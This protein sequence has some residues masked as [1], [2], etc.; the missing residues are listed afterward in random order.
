MVAPVGEGHQDGAPSAGRGRST[1]RMAGAPLGRWLSSLTEGDGHAAVCG[2]NLLEVKS[3]DEY[4]EE[5]G[6]SG[7]GCRP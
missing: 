6:D 3:R 7:V 4:T 5:E 2:P 1:T